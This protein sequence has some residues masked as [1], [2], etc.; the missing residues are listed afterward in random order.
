MRILLL[1]ACMI[2]VGCADVSENEEAAPSVRTTAETPP[3]KSDTGSADSEDDAET[4]SKT[5]AGLRFGIPKG[6]VDSPPKF[7]GIIAGELKIPAAGDSVSVTLSRAGGDIDDNLGRWRG[8]FQP[9]SRDEIM[10]DISVAGVTGSR[11]DLQGDFHP[12]F[13]RTAEGEW[14]MIGVVVPL[15]EQNYFIKL[16]GPVDEVSAVKDDFEK[17][18]RSAEAE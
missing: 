17:F 10:D 11:I 1:S 2:F 18:V 5:Y 13:G 16:T 7:A 4:V 15:G 3:S 9:Q 12:G 6:W 14:R 8:Q